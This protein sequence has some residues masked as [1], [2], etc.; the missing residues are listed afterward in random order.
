[1][2][3]AG[4]A[5]MEV[6]V[7]H[8]P[9]GLLRPGQIGVRGA[10]EGRRSGGR[11][12]QPDQD[13]QRRGLAGAVGPEEAGD[14][15]RFD[16]EA[17]V[18]DGEDA[19][20]RLD[21]PVDHDR[22]DRVSDGPRHAVRRA[23]LLGSAVRWLAAGCGSR[24]GPGGD[25]TGDWLGAA[26][27]RRDA[28]AGLRVVGLG[29]RRTRTRCRGR[30]AGRVGAAPPGRGGARRRLR[31]PASVGRRRS[32]R[33]RWS[34]RR[35]RAAR[36]SGAVRWSAPGRPAGR[37]TAAVPRPVEGPRR[38]GRP[39][40]AYGRTGAGGT[41]TGGRPG[42]VGRRSRGAAGAAG[43]GGAAARPVAGVRP[44][45]ASA[46]RA[47]GL[48]GGTRCAA[49]AGVGAGP[50]R[51]GTV[52]APEPSPP[53]RPRR[54]RRRRCGRARPAPGRAAAA[55]RRAPAGSTPIPAAAPARLD[56]RRPPSRGTAGCSWVTSAASLAA[57]GSAAGSARR[58]RLR[59][60][61][62]LGPRLR[63]GRRDRLRGLRNRRRHEPAGPAR[64]V[65]DGLVGVPG[66]G[67][68]RP[69]RSCHEVSLSGAERRGSG[70]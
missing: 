16:G 4:P 36:W 26:G 18:P 38:A 5:R 15:A 11:R 33:C 57:S 37:S 67:V 31:S 20:V 61:V 62:G 60:L 68:E 69:P 7:Q 2:V 41:G 21:Q 54:S 27:R 46:R 35:S 3:A 47:G 34:R 13:P 70:M 43:A 30:L 52:G 28:A 44:A 17:E 29:A 12:D 39:R 65:R 45:A 9:D 42:A 51:P 40:G 49:A 48:T 59:R 10:A 66:F 8:R 50:P 14:P 64:H 56:R 6:G 32:L 63:P 22:L 19:V 25:E 53:R 1:M 23:A 58:G 55:A 24:L